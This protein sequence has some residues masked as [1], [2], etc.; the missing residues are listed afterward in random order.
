[1]DKV[2]QVFVS[3]TFADLKEERQEVSNTL[4][5]AGYIAAGMELFPATDQQ[6][7]EYIQRVI[8]R[9]DY[10]VVIIGARYGSLA[11]DG[12]SYTEKEFDYARSKGIPVLAFLHED[13]RSLPIFKTDED[14]DKAALLDSFKGRLKTGRIVQ[15]WKDT[16]DLC[17]KVVI[18]VINAVN[19]K[20]GIGWVRGDQAFDPLILQD[21]ERLRIENSQLRD[22]LARLQSEEPDSDW[23]GVDDPIHLVAAGPGEEPLHI[24]A[25]IGDIFIEIYNSLLSHDAEMH[26]RHVVAD[27]ALRLAGREFRS[28]I[29]S[30][31]IVDEDM[32]KLRNQLEALGLVRPISVKLNSSGS[33][34]IAWSATDKGRRYAVSRLALRKLFSPSE[35]EKTT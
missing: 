19:L 5:K 16:N 21:M 4:A 32:S 17:T 11:E 8:D 13:P 22:R 3:S 14:S 30:P 35:S 34:V 27:V 29:G 31:Y 10:Y 2:Y 1:M 23:L 15:F 18:A 24:D 28:P 33:S 20:P 12:K 26:L 7:L 6:Q 9:C 25:K